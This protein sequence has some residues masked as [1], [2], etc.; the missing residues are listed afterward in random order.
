MLMKVN[1]TINEY[2]D[3]M[4]M[5]IRF[6]IDMGKAS[7]PFTTEV[8]RSGAKVDYEELSGGQKQLVDICIAFAMH[9][10][11]SSLNNLNI[12]ILDEVFEGLDSEMIEQ[13]FELIMFKTKPGMSTY[14][15]THSNDITYNKARNFS[16]T[17]DGISSYVED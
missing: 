12:L 17:Y 3:H 2:A 16:V 1:E 11:V 10:I 9:E 13:V 14:V 15:I 8:Y 6:T 5:K 7:K 4:Q